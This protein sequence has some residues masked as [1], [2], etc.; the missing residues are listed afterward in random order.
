MLEFQLFELRRLGFSLNL[1]VDELELITGPLHDFSPP[2]RANTKPVN[3][4][5][6]RNRAIALNAD[7]EPGGVQSVDSFFVELQ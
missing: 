3:S 2:F 6:R 1:R 4:L 7:L 5:R